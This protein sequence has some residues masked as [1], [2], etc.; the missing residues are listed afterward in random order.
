[1]KKKLFWTVFVCIFIVGMVPG[2]WAAAPAKTISLKFSMYFPPTS[3]QAL[4]W[5]QYCK[6]IEKRTNGQ[7]KITYYPGSQ[8]F[9]GPGTWDAVRKG[10]ADLGYVTTGHASGRFLVT[11]AVTVM[12][13]YPSAFVVSR[14]ADDY[15]KKFTPKEFSEYQVL[16]AA[17]NSPMVIF[18]RKPFYKLEDFK[19]T[20]TRTSGRQADQVKLLGVAPVSMPAGESVDALSKGVIDSSLTSMEAAKTWRLAEVCKYC[21]LSWSVFSPPAYYTVMNKAKY[22][23]L[24]A[25]VKAV[26]DKVSEEWVDKSALM[27]NNTDVVGA[28]FSKEKGMT[29]ID[30]SPEEAK[31]WRDLVAPAA[32]AYIQTMV[33]KGFSKQ[34]VQGWLD[35]LKSRIDFWLKEQIKRGIKSPIGPPE[36]RG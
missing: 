20:K 6:E 7:V 27:S 13:G 28:Q 31:R 29:F 23:G 4:L 14:V 36:I 16:A 9:D 2:A 21:T 35:Y 24:P 26:F 19:G 34:E 17:G 30:L 25:D 10:V 5:E 18:S 32:D 1:M 22:D 12:T 8:L 15:Y 3:D 11:E 33:G